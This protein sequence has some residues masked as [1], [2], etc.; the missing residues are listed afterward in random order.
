M[1]DNDSQQQDEE[2][3][4]AFEAIFAAT[5]YVARY[6]LESLVREVFKEQDRR[7]AE[8]DDLISTKNGVKF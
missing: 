1:N 5:D 6:G 8:L 3:R 4:A 7:D 2:E